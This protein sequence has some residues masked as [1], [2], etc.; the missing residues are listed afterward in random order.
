MYG[1][2]VSPPVVVSVFWAHP[3][4][5]TPVRPRLR[6]PHSGRHTFTT[7]RSTTPAAMRPRVRLLRPGALLALTAHDPSPPPRA[8]SRVSED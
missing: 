4:F 6:Y 7:G 1:S 2:P 3:D 5:P 8:C